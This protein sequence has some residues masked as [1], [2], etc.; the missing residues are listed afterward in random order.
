MT[1][2]EGY[3]RESIIN[4]QAKIVKGY[5]P[6]M[7]AFQGLVSEDNLVALVEYVKIAVAD[8]DH[9]RRDAGRHDPDRRSH[10]R[11]RSG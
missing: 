9:A 5:Q 11:T 3:L 10:Q 7:P 8:G 1:V 6:L 4:S 2:D